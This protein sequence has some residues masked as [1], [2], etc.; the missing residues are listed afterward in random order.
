MKLKHLQGKREKEQEHKVMRQL[1]R[2]GGDAAGGLDQ[3]IR[4]WPAVA[5]VEGRQ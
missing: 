3:I 5:N 2:R 4:G 1:E